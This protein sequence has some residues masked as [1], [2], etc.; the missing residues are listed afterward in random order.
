MRMRITPASDSSLYIGFGDVTLLE[1][2]RQVVSAFR[3]LENLHDTRIRNLHPAYTS[4]LID[5]DPLNLTH[6]EVEG[7][8]GPLVSEL[9]ASDHSKTRQIEIPVCYESEF[10]PDLGNVAN[11]L[12]LTEEQIIG[13]HLSSEYSVYF[14]GFAPGFAYL[15]GLVPQLHVPRLATPRKHVAAGSVAIAGAQTGIYPNDSP[16]GWQLIGRTPLQMF[17]ADTDPPSLT[18]PG[19]QV[20]FRRIDRAEFDR[21]YRER[22]HQQ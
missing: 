3:A 5:F 1:A 2:H 9:A 10:A 7:M 20:R 22:D 17:D 18:Q 6:E 19:D 16:G 4:L 21:L 12:C 15:G 11:K 8:I 14:L 13:L